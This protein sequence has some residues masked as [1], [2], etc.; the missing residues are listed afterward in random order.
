MELF[1]LR[2]GGKVIK[3][4][5]DQNFRPISVLTEGLTDGIFGVYET[6]MIRRTLLQHTV[7]F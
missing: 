1:A 5:N 6:G 2:E 4:E 3:V 7:F